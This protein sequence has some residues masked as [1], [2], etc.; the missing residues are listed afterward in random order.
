[1]S[2]KNL[3]TYIL[4][5]LTT[6]IWGGAFVAGKI[7]TTTLHPVS[8]AFFRFFGASLILF[9]LLHWK[10]RN[11]PIPVKKD[12]GVLALLGL[13]G[14]FLYNIFFF[15]ATKYAPIVKSS[16]V[17]AVNA[18]LI[19]LLSALFLKEKLNRR[20]VL[21]MFLAVFGAIYII[22]DGH[23]SVLI[24]IGFSPIDLVLVGACLSWS[25]YSVIGKIAMKKFSPLAATT[26]AT[27]FGTL[28]LA[29]FALYYTSFASIEASGWDVWLSVL[30]VAIFVSAISF[31][32]WYNG[33]QKVGA[34][35][36]SVFINVM[37]IS[38]TVMGTMFFNE[39]LTLTHIIGAAFV[40][41]G[42]L[43]NIYSKQENVVFS[44]IKK[45]ANT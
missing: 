8:V 28:F 17:I 45:E 2:T 35:T 44:L 19:T 9:P 38:A 6:T 27:G 40:F 10:E 32:W 25:T 31:V 1:M 39:H 36:A 34:S 30:Y 15:I 41:S 21:G 37:P 22:T 14:V 26:Y 24:D 11:R 43:L 20:S 3:N 16:L 29:P 42:I 7:A 23:P 5:F 33:I 13:T 18:P 12:W 4:L